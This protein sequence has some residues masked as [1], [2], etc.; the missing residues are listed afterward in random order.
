MDILKTI[1]KL[2][3]ERQWS[4]YQLA[5]KANLPQS[6][7]SSWYR[8]NMQPS[9]ASLEKICDAFDLTLAEFFSAGSENMMLDSEQ[10]EVL[11]CWRKLDKT[12]RTLL[13]RFLKTL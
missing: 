10:I 2:R 3:Q 1:T 11:Q 5:V 7:I 13:L 6:T 9:L 8:R 4:E 12:Q